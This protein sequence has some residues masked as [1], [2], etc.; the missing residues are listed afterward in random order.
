MFFYMS[1][2]IGFFL[3]PSNLLCCLLVLGLALQKTR[4]VR[5]GRTILTGA[6]IALVILAFS[7]LGNMFLLPLEERFSQ[8]SIDTP[9]KAPYGIIVLGGSIDTL[10]SK[11]RGTLALNE[12]A[13]RLFEAVKLA[14][15]YPEARLL[16]SGGSGRIL[17]ETMS[18]ADAVEGF[19][20]D[21][22]ISSERLIFER[23]AK[24]TWQN[25]L[26]TKKLLE[27]NAN[28]RWLLVT[29]AFHMPR[30]VGCFR[31]VGINIIPWPTDYRTRGKNDIYRILGIAANGWKRADVAVREW[32]GLVVY[33]ITGRTEH[34]Y[35]RPSPRATSS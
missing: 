32:I 34:L 13:E 35:P 10:V 23:A 27:S 4:F 31:K 28:K 26:F 21:M 3:L 25:A 15:R 19:F 7:P 18:E 22:G 29:S 33:R 20:A 12:S 11:A 8:P 2:I 5:T 24:N 16:F 30:S 14:R 1:K 17:Y 6:I 9:L